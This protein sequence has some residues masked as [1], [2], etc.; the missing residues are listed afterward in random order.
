[1]LARNESQSK[2]FRVVW[3]RLIYSEYL[4]GILLVQFFGYGNVLGLD[5]AGGFD[6]DGV[7]DEGKDEH[8]SVRTHSEKDS[9]RIW[10]VI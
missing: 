4:V 2:Y 6:F 1:M 7:V 8:G 3:F 5:E 10:V 9:P